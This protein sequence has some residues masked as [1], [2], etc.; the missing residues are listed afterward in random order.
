MAMYAL[1]LIPLARELLPLCRQICYADDASGCDTFASLRHWYDT[2]ITKGPLYGY[3]PSPK[4]C[5]LVVKSD[6]LAAANFYF[7]GTGI[8]V[9]VE[10]SKDTGVEMNTQGTRHLGAPT[11]LPIVQRL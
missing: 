5:I 3:Y 1:T 9:S 6:K 11:K 8:T 10:G 7:K 4:K 2:L